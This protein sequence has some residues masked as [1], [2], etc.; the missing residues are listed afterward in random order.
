MM[1][2]TVISWL[3]YK[4]NSSVSLAS[5]RL[6]V[7]YCASSSMEKEMHETPKKSCSLVTNCQG[8]LPCLLLLHM[9]LPAVSFTR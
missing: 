5:E 6:S 2:L 7:H 4:I 9:A 3:S 1:R 8:I